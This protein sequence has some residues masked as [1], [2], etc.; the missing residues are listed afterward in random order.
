MDNPFDEKIVIF[1]KDKNNNFIKRCTY[2][3]INIT[4]YVTQN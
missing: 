2:T 4:N 3:I 1:L